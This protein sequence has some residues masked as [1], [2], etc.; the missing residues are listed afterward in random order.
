MHIL[1][2]LKEGS[3]S[4]FVVFSHSAKNKMPS[5]LGEFSI[6]C[7]NGGRGLILITEAKVGVD[8]FFFTSWKLECTCPRIGL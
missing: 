4:V 8:T 6:V 2:N 5:D 1:E 7:L 3:Y